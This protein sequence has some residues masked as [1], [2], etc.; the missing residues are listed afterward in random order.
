MLFLST[1]V[2]VTAHFLLIRHA[3]TADVDVRLSGRRPGVSLSQKGRAQAETISWLLEETP[4]DALF[5]SPLERTRETAEILSDACGAPVLEEPALLEID[6]GEWTGVTFKVLAADPR[7]RSWNEERATA[8]CPGGETMAQAQAR[9]VGCMERLA[10]THEDETIALVTHSDLIRAAV[11]HILGLG[12]AAVHRFDI[13]SASVTRV[14][15]GDWGGRV[16]SM[17]EKG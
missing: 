6:V 1:R 2:P 16:L 11:C 8:C 12:L 7:W 4:V 10:L 14:V 9:I 13:D 15:L 17:N 5:A 3:V